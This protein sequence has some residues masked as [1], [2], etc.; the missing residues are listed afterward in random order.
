LPVV[1]QEHPVLLA[2]IGL[3]R[4]ISRLTSWRTR[5][6]PP[7]LSPHHRQPA[8]PSDRDSCSL[9]PA[10]QPADLCQRQISIR[11]QCSWQ[12]GSPGLS[13]PGGWTWPG[14][15]ASIGAP[16]GQSLACAC[17][18]PSRADHWGGLEGW[19]TSR[20]SCSEPPQGHQVCPEA[21]AKFQ[22]F[23]KSMF[24]FKSSFWTHAKTSLGLMSQRLWPW[25]LDRAA[26]R[27]LVLLCR[28]APLPALLLTDRIAKAILPDPYGSQSLSRIKS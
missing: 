21:T 15:L 4:W 17:S 8:T 25:R 13:R 14:D 26:S 12:L 9:P 28:S 27:A 23:W 11:V 10:G 19:N 1:S 7:A 20:F 2:G 24:S 16:L 18:R 5:S 3:F 6:N 22:F